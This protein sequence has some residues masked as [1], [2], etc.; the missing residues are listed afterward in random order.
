MNVIIRADASNVIGS[1]HVMRCLSLADSLSQK[2]ANVTFICRDLPE[3]LFSLVNKRNFQVIPLTAKDSKKQDFNLL[4]YANNNGK[5]DWLIIDHY[6]L[7]RD[8]ERQARPYVKKIL[9]IDDFT[10]RAHDCDVLLNQNFYEKP[11]SL[12]KG[13]LPD[14]CQKLVGPSFALLHS[15]FREFRQKLR[16][17]DGLIKK[18]LI[19]FGSGDSTGETIKSLKTITLLNNPEIHWDVVVGENNVEKEAI[20]GLC[21]KIPLSTFHCQTNNMPQLMHQADLALGAGG[22]TTWERCCMSLPSL[23]IS[24]ASNQESIAKSADTQKFGIY[25]GPSQ[26]VTPQLIKDQLETLLANPEKVLQF[27]KNASVLVDGNGGNRV[28]QILFQ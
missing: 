4:N 15:T 19:F 27:S 21:K 17:R 18:V 3:N 10:H 22:S 1:G 20:K 16:R 7:N 24:T 8:W 12:Y 28:Q 6:D 2:R 26:K 13:L 5:P 23:L 25:L 9:V 11:Q 14:T